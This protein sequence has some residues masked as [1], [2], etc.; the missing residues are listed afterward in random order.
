[1]MIA[2]WQ[3]D[4]R[5]GYKQ[6]AIEHLQRW[7]R[8]IAPQVGIKPERTRLLTGSVGALEATIQT[9]HQIEDLA[10]LEHVWGKLA[11]IPAHAQWG[12]ELEPFV[13]SGTSRWEIY[14]VL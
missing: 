7:L 14:R 9:E 2:R 13:V 11:T 8:E 5:F 10:E 3:I 1:M 6:G 12:K 4:A